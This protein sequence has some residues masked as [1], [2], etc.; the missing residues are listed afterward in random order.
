MDIVEKIIENGVR[1]TARKTGF[2]AMY[3]SEIKTG[4]RKLAT[5]EALFNL[6]IKMGL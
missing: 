3:I 1:K 5:T 6:A 4:K 2:S